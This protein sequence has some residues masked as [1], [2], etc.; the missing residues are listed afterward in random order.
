MIKVDYPKFNFK[1]KTEA[2]K[3]I[4]FDE[5]RKQWVT[6]TPE[7]WVR[8]NTIQYL[9]QSLHY[10]ASLIAVE[11]A[12]KLGELKKR[13]DILV[14]NQQ[15]QP[16]LMIECKA[17]DV[18]LTESVLQQVLRYNMA[19]PVAYLFITNG[20]SI[21]GWHVKDNCKMLDAFPSF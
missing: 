17:V 8:Q 6:L 10:P 15:H 12:L 14:Y 5:I 13:F 20:E 2:G 21:F 16:W 4:I 18:A 3:E 19:I 9:L 11:K 7:E 1:I